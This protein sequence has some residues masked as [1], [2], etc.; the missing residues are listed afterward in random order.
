MLPTLL[1]GGRTAFVTSASGATGTS[2]SWKFTMRID[3]RRTFRFHG[4]M[5]L[6]VLICALASGATAAVPPALTAALETFRGEAPKFWS[7]TQT[8]AAEGKSTV[9]RYDAAKPEFDRWT[10]RQ[11]DGRAPTAD[12]AQDYA[13]I[14]SRR[15][16]GGT[17]PKLTD[18]FDLATAETVSDTPERATY[19]LKMKPAEVDDR[20]AAF[21]RVT[22]RVH[23][24]THTVES[25]ELASTGEF[26]PTFA[27]KI[28]EMI[29]TLTYSVPADGLPSLPQAVTT[30]VRGR[31]FLFKSLDADMTVTFT[32]Y[33]RVG[34]NIPSPSSP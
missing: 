22:V 15:S 24:P 4:A 31:A 16:R 30:H 9:E 17:A 10:L 26:S 20:T 29:T 27:V 12:E 8:T 7:F 14:R 28:A 32:D 25:I 23:K 21:L 6:L 11:K 34:K 19:R 3:S 13:E 2:L 1:P 33:E 18:Q 5:R